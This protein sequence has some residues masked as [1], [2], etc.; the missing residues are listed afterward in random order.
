MG[1]RMV[2]K[3]LCRSKRTRSSS[4]IPEIEADYNLKLT[5]DSQRKGECGNEFVGHKSDISWV[6]KNE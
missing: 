2:L 5:W 1:E 3:Q 4:S 6:T